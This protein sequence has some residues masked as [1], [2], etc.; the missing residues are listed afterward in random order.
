MTALLRLVDATREILS[1]I[2]KT[3]AEG[4][5]DDAELI[6]TLKEL[7]KDRTEETSKLEPVT[8]P[9]A[10]TSVMGETQATG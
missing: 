6:A 7:Q 9:V 8:S 1:S 10:R 2:E 5:R 4:E 3:E